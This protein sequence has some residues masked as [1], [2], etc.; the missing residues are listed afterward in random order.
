M[1]RDTR[2]MRVSDQM[3]AKDENAARGQ[4]AAA[5][6]SRS[7]ET[8]SSA[9]RD[10]TM[11]RLAVPSEDEGGLNARRSGHFGKSACFTVI[12]IDH[13][14]PTSVYSWPTPPTPEAARDLSSS[15]LRTA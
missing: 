2:E 15:W 6:E 11:I 7:G 12:E 9:V 8:R 14:K 5:G 4:L 10:H 13:G 1:E 3:M